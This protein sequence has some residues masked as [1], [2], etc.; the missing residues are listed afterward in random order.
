MKFIKEFA[1]FN[2]EEYIPNPARV[3]DIREEDLRV[4]RIDY[5]KNIVKRTLLEI[6]EKID[7]SRTDRERDYYTNEY[8]V[9]LKVF[10]E[11]CDV[12]EEYIESKLS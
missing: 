4:F 10:A 11:A 2:G 1:T 8:A 6:R 12:T 5:F 7:K 3:E 9:M